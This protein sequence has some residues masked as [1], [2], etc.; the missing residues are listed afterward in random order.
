MTH[1]CRR[2]TPYSVLSPTRNK[3][4]DQCSDRMGGTSGRRVSDGTTWVAGLI[5]G[6]KRHTAVRLSPDQPKN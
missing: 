6:H 4:E 2:Q 5:Q 3:S 1:S